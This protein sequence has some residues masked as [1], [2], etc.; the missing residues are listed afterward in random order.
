M[1]FRCKICERAP[2][3]GKTISHSHTAT[4]RWFKPN[5]QRVKVRYQGKVQHMYVC[6]NCLRS[7]KVTKV[8]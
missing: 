1:S 3:G 8:V 6:T 5:L 2:H 7:N 4:N